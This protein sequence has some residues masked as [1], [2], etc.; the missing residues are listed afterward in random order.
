MSRLLERKD[1]NLNI[2]AL[3]RA[4]ENVNA[5]LLSRGIGSFG[6]LFQEV[7]IPMAEAQFR[8]YSYECLSSY[9]FSDYISS[10]IGVIRPRFSSDWSFICAAPLQP[11]LS[12]YP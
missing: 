8:Q 12:L 2:I 7:A 1:P 10:T 6:M 11:N 9:H 5:F 3:V 4:V